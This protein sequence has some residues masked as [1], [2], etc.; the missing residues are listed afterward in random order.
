MNTP[1]TSYGNSSPSAFN[2]HDICAVVLFLHTKVLECWECE[3]VSY[4]DLTSRGTRTP[5][6]KRAADLR[7]LTYRGHC[8]EGWKPEQSLRLRH[9]VP[10]PSS[11]CPVNMCFLLLWLLSLLDV[12]MWSG[13]FPGG[14]VPIRMCARQSRMPLG[15]EL[16][17]LSGNCLPRRGFISASADHNGLLHQMTL[18]EQGFGRG[19]ASPTLRYTGRSGE[20]GLWGQVGGRLMSK[21][22]RQHWREESVSA[23]KSA[24]QSKGLSRDPTN[25]KEWGAFLQGFNPNNSVRKKQ[26][27]KKCRQK[28]RNTWKKN[29][30]NNLIGGWKCFKEK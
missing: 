7:S 26:T 5:D 1:C 17:L 22:H 30:D 20:V 2:S 29:A 8:A 3:T 18:D 25:S 13:A 4:K 28:K 19:A 9:T 6:C 15:R 27:I 11:G 23:M 21:R 16:R 12:S 24:Q 14:R 10:L